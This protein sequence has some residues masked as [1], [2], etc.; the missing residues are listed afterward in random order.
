[1]WEFLEI[2][3]SNKLCRGF[4]WAIGSEGALV[5]VGSGNRVRD[6]M[7]DRSLSASA[8]VCLG[9]TQP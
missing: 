7:V 2:E 3:R 1:M 4:L 6:S 8:G 5:A 9:V